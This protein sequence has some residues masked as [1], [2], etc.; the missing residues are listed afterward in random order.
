MAIIIDKLAS[1]DPRAQIADNVFIG[2]FCV[3]GPQAEI[4]AGT[5]LENHVT[6]SGIVKIG[7]N[8]R[9][10]ANAVIGADPQDISYKGTETQVVIGDNNVFR[11][12]VTVNRA[13][14]KEDGVTAVGSNC[15]FMATVHIAHDCKLGDNIIIGNASMLGGHVHVQ[16]NAT[17]SGAVGVHHFAS[18]G[19]YSFVS[20][21][22]R[23]L[24]DVPPYMLVEGIPTR[25][26]CVNVVALKRKNFPAEVIRALSE[27]YR[28]L[29]RAKVGL[30]NAREILK[31]NN[32]LFPAVENLFS[33]IEHQ[34]GG[35]HGRGRDRRRAA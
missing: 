20:G 13:S 15:Y 5:R 6:I 17:L 14:E 33:F 9:F 3:V 29:Y 30:T 35:R 26:R 22:S 21:V 31:N 27:A 18:V 32:S 8:N 28:L 19:T 16:D 12:G 23:V 2:P 7:D 24:H 34:Q 1:V 11:E 4:G 25:P 10:F